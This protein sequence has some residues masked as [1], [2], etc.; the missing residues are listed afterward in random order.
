[1]TRGPGIEHQDTLVGGER[2][3]HCAIPAPQNKFCYRLFV[4]AHVLQEI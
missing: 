4:L 2:F 3:H 1:M